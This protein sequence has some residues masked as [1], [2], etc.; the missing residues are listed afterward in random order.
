MR[1]SVHLM[2]GQ[3]LAFVVVWAS[4]HCD[5]AAIICIEGCNI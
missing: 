2:M 3:L 1:S 4:L 5:T